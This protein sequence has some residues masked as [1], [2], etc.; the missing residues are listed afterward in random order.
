MI[1][2]VSVSCTGIGLPSKLEAECA[3]CHFDHTE[4]KLQQSALNEVLYH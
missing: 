1:S 2:L 4:Q 3:A